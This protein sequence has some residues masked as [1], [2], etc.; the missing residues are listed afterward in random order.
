MRPRRCTGR[1]AGVEKD[2]AER[3]LA[4]IRD[5]IQNTREDLAEHNWGRI[6]ICHAFTNAAG[7]GAIGYFVEGRGHSVVSYLVPLAITA[8]INVGIIALIL[9]R[10]R[11]IR[12]YVEGQ[13]H[14]IWTSFVVLTLAGA[15]AIEAAGLEP[16]LLG[17]ILALNAGFGFAMMGVVFSARFFV[18]AVAFIVV[19]VI[20]PSLVDLQWYVIGITWW[21]ALIAPGITFSRERKRRRSNGGT[22]TIA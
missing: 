9:D 11:G 20:S 17:M 8:A 10:D 4:I 15:A 22:T 6:W 13:I 19:G 1:V 7:L 21:F 5:T 14:G 12:S 16:S 18:T 3:A 2:Q